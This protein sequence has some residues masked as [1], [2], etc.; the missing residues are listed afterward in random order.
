VIPPWTSRGKSFRRSIPR[1]SESPSAV[2]DHPSGVPA[3][4]DKT[5]EQKIDLR[6]EGIEIIQRARQERRAE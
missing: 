1:A 3:N 2:R 5:T 6:K 4:D